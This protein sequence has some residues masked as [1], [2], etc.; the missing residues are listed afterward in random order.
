M[1]EY[2]K[3]IGET[4]YDNLPI[5]KSKSE[6]FTIPMPGTLGGATITFKENDMNTYM[7]NLDV[8]HLLEVKASSMDEAIEKATHFQETMPKGWGDHDNFDVCWVD[9]YIVK[10]SAER[11]INI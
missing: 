11:D 8:R 7:V 4:Y 10:E 6:S 3:E 9:T 2:L 1:L 5:I